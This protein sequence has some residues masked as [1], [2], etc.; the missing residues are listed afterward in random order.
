MQFQDPLYIEQP[1]PELETPQN[2]QEQAPVATGEPV[3]PQPTVEDV[4][5]QYEAQIAQ[6]RQQ[7]DNPQVQGR[8]ESTID[9]RINGGIQRAVAPLFAEIQ[10]L[11]NSLKNPDNEGQPQQLDEQR[12]QQLIQR[13]VRGV[14]TEEMGI[15]PQKIQ[16]TNLQADESR[17]FSENPAAAD[18]DNGYGVIFK[19]ILDEVK[20]HYQVDYKMLG[21]ID[22]AVKRFIS[23]AQALAAQKGLSN[24]LPG[25][26]SG[27]GT[28]TPA[29]PPKNSISPD[30]QQNMRQRSEASS[31]LRPGVATVGQPRPKAKTARDIVRFLNT[32]VTNVPN[33]Q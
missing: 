3:T 23:S 21:V 18:Q 31:T 24:S 9:R 12:I 5:A 25:A 33:E 32:G 17:F 4:K 15:D 7:I 10:E 13:G 29:N 8:L 19:P 22:A 11:R 28:G 1:K 26:G 6:L 2:G 16:M 14:L 20:Q 30:Q 27:G